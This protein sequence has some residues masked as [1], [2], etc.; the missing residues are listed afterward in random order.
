MFARG[1]VIRSFRT[2]GT[3][4]VFNGA[5]TKAA[6][7][8]CPEQ[9][10]NVARRKLQLINAAFGLGDLRVLPGNRLEALRGDRQGRYSIRINEQ[11]RICFEWQGNDAE[12][13]EIADYH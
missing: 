5:P 2:Q 10:M 6:R 8:T 3:E 11:Y 1:H 12:N 13:V 4:D 7:R 9:I